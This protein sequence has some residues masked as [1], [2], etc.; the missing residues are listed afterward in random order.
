MWAG[1]PTIV[2]ADRSAAR[3]FSLFQAV[4]HGEQRLCR[5]CLWSVS[6]IP[7]PQ[8]RTMSNHGNLRHSEFRDRSLSPS[9]PALQSG[10]GLHAAARDK[11]AVTTIFGT[12]ICAPSGRAAPPRISTSVPAPLLYRTLAPL[13]RSAEWSGVIGEKRLLWLMPV[14]VFIKKRYDIVPP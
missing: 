10:S 4:Q 5:A 12:T 7:P 2:L 6:V 13:R 9:S 14:F 1:T 11:T 8:G 3:R